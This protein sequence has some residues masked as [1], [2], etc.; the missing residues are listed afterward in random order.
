MDED[1]DGDDDVVE[2]RKEWGNAVRF[3]DSSALRKPQEPND[4]PARVI[5]VEP[6]KSAPVG[7]SRDG[8]Q[9]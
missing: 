9:S 1:D 3:W 5:K 6:A 7:G 4:E 2:D 8:D